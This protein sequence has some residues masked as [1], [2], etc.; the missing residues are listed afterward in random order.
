MR[1]VSEFSR[2]SS[3]RLQLELPYGDTYRAY[4]FV[5]TGRPSTAP[6]AAAG[7]G[8]VYASWNGETGI[9]RW[10]ALAGPDRAH[11]RVVGTAPWAGLETAIPADTSSATVV[12]VR[13]LDA[14][15]RVLGT[16][17]V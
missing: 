10:E 15:G 8:V 17:R 13:A 6:K 11:L 2:S 7:V 4:R 9:A 1:F 5:W 3:L 12:V 16:S 14:R